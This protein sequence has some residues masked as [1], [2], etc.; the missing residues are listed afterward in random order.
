M[1][2]MVEMNLID[3][4][5]VKIGIIGM[6]RIQICFKHSWVSCNAEVRVHDRVAP[7]ATLP[8]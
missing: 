1:I 6:K 5:G 3:K 2:Y 4:I 7:F 8:C